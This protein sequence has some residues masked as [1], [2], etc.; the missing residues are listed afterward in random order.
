MEHKETVRCDCCQEMYH[1]TQVTSAY[2]L[3]SVICHNCIDEMEDMFEDEDA[4]RNREEKMDWYESS[5][6]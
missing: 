4:A 2:W 5:P 6:F 3:N 1:P